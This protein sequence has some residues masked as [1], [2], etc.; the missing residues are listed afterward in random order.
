M[1]KKNKLYFGDQVPLKY[2]LVDFSILNHNFWSTA[3]VEMDI[4]KLLVCVY[5]SRKNLV[6]SIGLVANDPIDHTME[7]TE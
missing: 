6:Y 2:F 4:R 7:R 3:L 1:Y 5:T